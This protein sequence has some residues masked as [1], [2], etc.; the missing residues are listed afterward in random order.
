M[1]LGS[2]ACLC[3]CACE[4]VC[5]CGESVCVVVLVRLLTRQR[6]HKIEKQLIR[7]KNLQRRQHV[8]AGR[9]AN[10]SWRGPRDGLPVTQTTFTNST[11][12]SVR[13]L[14]AAQRDTKM[15]TD[16]HTQRDIDTEGQRLTQPLPSHT[17]HNRTHNPAPTR[18]KSRPKPRLTHRDQ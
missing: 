6:S 1:C 12:K 11:T 2:L 16:N 8:S 10:G 7:T 9:T 18:P 3:V 14:Q 13:R 5:E 4:C 15:H 17:L